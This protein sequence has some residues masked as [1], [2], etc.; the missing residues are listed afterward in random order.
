MSS[1]I[2]KQSTVHN[3]TTF[4]LKKII[5]NNR[6]HC[7]IR[8]G[9][10]LPEYI[11]QNNGF[12]FPRDPED[13]D[14][15]GEKHLFV[16]IHDVYTFF[17]QFPDKIEKQV[18][19]PQDCEKWEKYHDGICYFSSVH[20]R[21]PEPIE[22]FFGVIF[23]SI[24]IAILFFFCKKNSSPDSERLPLHSSRSDYTR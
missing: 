23:I 5:P 3:G 11:C 20:H 21:S 24:I 16:R 15:L 1:H 13:A 19:G 8:A 14:C 7:S 10:P 17:C 12:C 22:P 2:Q 9:C 6:Y 4:Q 18:D